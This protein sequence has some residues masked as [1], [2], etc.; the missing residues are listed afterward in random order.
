MGLGDSPNSR[1]RSEKREKDRK[2]NR[3]RE[4][5]INEQEGIRKYRIERERVDFEET[6]TAEMKEKVDP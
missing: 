4:R 6:A 5:E 2:R 1:K 3:E